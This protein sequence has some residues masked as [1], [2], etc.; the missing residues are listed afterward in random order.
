MLNAVDLAGLFSDVTSV[1]RGGVK[2]LL[3][4]SL[5]LPCLFP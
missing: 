1:I 4:S 5:L 3:S 2:V